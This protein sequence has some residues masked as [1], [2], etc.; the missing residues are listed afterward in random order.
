MSQVL[1]NFLSTPLANGIEGDVGW[2]FVAFDLDPS[3]LFCSLLVFLLQKRSWLCMKDD[4]G[5]LKRF[6]LHS[7]Q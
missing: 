4:R 5:Q 7:L 1:A 3:V 2:P 6:A